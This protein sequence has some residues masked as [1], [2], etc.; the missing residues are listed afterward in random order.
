M[1]MV[2]I[3][4]DDS[5]FTVFMKKSD[6]ENKNFMEINNIVGLTITRELDLVVNENIKKSVFQ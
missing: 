5:Y 1:L 4:P 2:V 6:L 3:Q